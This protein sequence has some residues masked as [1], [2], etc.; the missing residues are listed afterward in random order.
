[1]TKVSGAEVW[2][3]VDG[4]ESFY[5]V[6]NLGRV[7]SIRADALMTPVPDKDGYPRVILRIDGKHYTRKVHR[8][9]CEAFNGPPTALHHEVH[10]ID[11]DRSNACADNLRWVSRRENMHRDQGFNTAGE[12]NGFSRLTEGSVRRIYRNKESMSAK[13]LAAIFGVKPCTVYEIW[14]GKRWPSVTGEM[15]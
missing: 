14:S 9:V 6:S 4:F 7:R 15:A 1:M 13:E 5:E 12:Q 8:L 3:G 10:H 2:R 11:N